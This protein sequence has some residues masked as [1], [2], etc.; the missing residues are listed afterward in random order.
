MVTVPFPHLA[1]LAAAVRVYLDARVPTMG[2]FASGRLIA[3]PQF[4]ARL[5]DHELVFVLA[6]A[7]AAFGREDYGLT[8]DL[9]RDVR[10]I[11]HRFGGSHAQR[12]V[13]AL[14]LVEA[15]LRNHARSLAK[16]L[17][18]ERMCLKPNSEGN[19]QLASRAAAL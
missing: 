17:T 1:G 12:D 6:H 2:V 14:T 5:N 3:N 13:L 11:S 8:V 4:A 9:L 19:R 18:A 15:A 16:V 10:L 7:L